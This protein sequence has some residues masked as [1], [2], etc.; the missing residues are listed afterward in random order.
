MVRSRYTWQGIDKHL[1]IEAG[2]LPLAHNV[3]YS[4]SYVMLFSAILGQGHAVA[5][6][7]SCVES[8]QLTPG[9]DSKLN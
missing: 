9:C 2:S 1:T 3:G 6:W 8:E 7:D 4:T 5:K